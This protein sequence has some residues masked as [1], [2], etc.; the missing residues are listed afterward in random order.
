MRDTRADAKID[1]KEG[2][3]FMNPTHPPIYQTII[4]K[5]RGFTF[6]TSAMGTA[7]DRKAHPP[8]FNNTHNLNGND[9][10]GGAG[11]R[12]GRG[13]QRSQ[14]GQRD[15]SHVHNNNSSSESK[16]DGELPPAAEAQ[17]PAQPVA[18]N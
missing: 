17:Q 16:R 11:G 10:R 3:V 14:G 15:R 13:G 2:M 12:G 4:E 1:F 6:R 8:S 18:A 7:I 9:K 5:T